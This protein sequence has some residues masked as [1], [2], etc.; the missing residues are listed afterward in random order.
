M[1][2][3]VL[4]CGPASLDAGESEIMK[5]SVGYQLPDDDEYGF[6]S[7]IADYKN[8]IDEIY[9]AW[10][11]QPSGRSPAGSCDGFTDWNAQEKLVADLRFFKEL[12]IKLNLLFNANC[13]GRISLSRQLAKTIC[14][15]IQHLDHLGGLDVVTTTSLMIAKTVKTEFPDINVRAS[16]NMRIGTVEGMDYVADLFD[17]FYVQREY[18]RDL[19]R[20]RK[21]AEWADVRKKDLHLLVNSGCLYGCSAQSFHDNLVAHE[22]EISSTDNI[23]GWNP[24]AC[25]NYLQDEKN[26]ARLLKNTWIRPEDLHHYEGLVKNFK[27]AT[28]M[29]SNPERVIKAY[30]TSR[31]AGNLLELF[32]PGH[33]RLLGDHLIDNQRF[34]ESWFARTTNCSRDCGECGY[35]DAVLRQVLVPRKDCRPIENPSIQ[36]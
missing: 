8:N 15:V 9:F 19:V 5:F 17:S 21:L 18:N 2:A 24:I 28:R 22:D 36:S 27:L 35:C 10:P 26:W 16:V 23:R 4:G 6:R 32:E 25:W 7:F 30:V 13:Y 3:A 12:G 34:P 33:E 1:A 29:H 11:G 31:Y 20:I 14:S